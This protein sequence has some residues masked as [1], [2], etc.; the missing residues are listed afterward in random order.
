MLDGVGRGTVKSEYL[1]EWPGE[2]PGIL[3]DLSKEVTP[4]EMILE[5]R[6]NVEKGKPCKDHGEE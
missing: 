4:A 3:E 1:R 5:L 6:S 2:S